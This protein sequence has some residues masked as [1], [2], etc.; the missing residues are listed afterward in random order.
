METTAEKKVTEKE[1]SIRGQIPKAG[2]SSVGYQYFPNTKSVTE[3]SLKIGNPS[4]NK[5]I[6][7]KNNMA[8][9]KNAIVKKK[10][11]ITFSVDVLLVILTFRIFGKDRGP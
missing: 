9:E 2:G 1:A 10:L 4:L 7:I 3:T 6:M 5:K 11:R 8:M